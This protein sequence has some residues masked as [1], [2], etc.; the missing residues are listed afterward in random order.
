MARITVEDCLTKENNR[1]ALV[2][3]A[4]KR[5]KQLLG[6]SRVLASD[7]KGNK[8][9]VTAL[10]E[11]AEGQVRFMNEE[12]ME[13][14]REREER[15]RE[16]DAQRRETQP[17]VGS[18]LFVLPTNGA[19]EKLAFMAD[20]DDEVDDEVDEEE[21]EEVDDADETDDEDELPKGD[22]LPSEDEEAPKVES[23]E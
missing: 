10:R 13:K 7:T 14:A 11:I 2:Q 12:D 9:V 16:L 1:F 22:K 4:S 15:Q 17:D 23:E 19:K 18:E 5:T 8:A 6:G 20:L 3:L 21:V